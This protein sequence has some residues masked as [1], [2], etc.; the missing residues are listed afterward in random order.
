MCLV[1]TEIKKKINPELSRVLLWGESRTRYLSPSRIFKEIPLEFWKEIKIDKR[2][3][4]AN[5]NKGMPQ[6]I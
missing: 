3:K 5:I 4:Y 2:R 1:K 6:S